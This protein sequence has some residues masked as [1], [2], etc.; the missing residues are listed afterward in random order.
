MSKKVNK[1]VLLEFKWNIH[2]N[3]SA[4]FHSAN[5]INRS[6]GVQS[7]YIHNYTTKLICSI[8]NSKVMSI[9]ERKLK[10]VL[11]YYHYYLHTLCYCNCYIG[12]YYITFRLYYYNFYYFLVHFVVAAV[13]TGILWSTYYCRVFF[14]IEAVCCCHCN[15]YFSL[16]YICSSLNLSLFL[17]TNKASFSTSFGCYQYMIIFPVCSLT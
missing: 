9:Y 12:C 15:S 8:I 17:S 13:V 11:L 10:W 1:I 6:N 2:S 7:K 14:M 4:E 5:W 16:D 3:H